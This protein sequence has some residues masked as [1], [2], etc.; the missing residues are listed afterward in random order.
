M[1]KLRF[2]ASQIVAPVEEFEAENAKLKRMYGELALEKRGDQGPAKPNAKRA[3][4]ALLVGED[5]LS[6]VR[7]CTIVPFSRAAY[8]RSRR[9]P[10][11]PVPTSSSLASRYGQRCRYIAERRLT[12]ECACPGCAPVF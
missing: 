2:T 9:Q 11:K 12:H 8:Y 3:A 6:V 1:G 10:S 7:A 5:G 4:A